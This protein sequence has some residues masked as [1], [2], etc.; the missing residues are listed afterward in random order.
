MHYTKISSRI[1]YN[2]YILLFSDSTS[3][4][5]NGVWDKSNHDNG[6]IVTTGL[7]CV[8]CLIGVYDSTNGSPLIGVCNQPFHKA[9]ESLNEIKYNI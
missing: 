8:T 5:V 4:Y 1:T 6:G 3:E 9:I 7:K 2:I